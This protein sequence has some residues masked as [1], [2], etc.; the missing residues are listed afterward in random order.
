MARTVVVGVEGTGPGHTALVWAAQAARAR[1]GDLEIVHAIG[2]RYEDVERRY[3]DARHQVTESLLN[4]ESARARQVTPGLTVRATLSR[5]TPGRALTE[6]SEHA[7]LMVVGSHPH[8]V[9]ERL[10]ARSFSYQMAAGARCPVLV[11]PHGMG[12]SGSGVVVGA[13][14][15]PDSVAAIALAAAEADRLHQ[16]LTVVHAWHSPMTYRVEDSDAGSHDERLQ[17]LECMVLAESVAGLRD[18]YP[19]L[20]VRR[21]LAHQH[22]ADALLGAAQGARLVVVGCRGIH[23]VARRLLGSVSRSVV[24]RAPCPVL[25]VRS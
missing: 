23:G 10:F 13:D 11:V 24:L 4:G 2:V 16:A 21:R 7:A 8:S 14:G 9:I 22:A 18:H 1:K 6:A 15:S 5:K 12:D 3:D 19:D 17:E 20:V 25:V